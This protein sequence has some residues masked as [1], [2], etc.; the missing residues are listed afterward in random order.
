MG[1]ALRA[2]WV[3]AELGTSCETVAMDFSKGEHRSDWFLAINPMGQ[4][5]AMQE[6]EFNLA[7]SMAIGSYLIERA[8]S[9][10][11]G[12]DAQQR[13]QAWQWSLWSGL[14]LQPHLSTLAAPAWTKQPLAP[15]VEAAAKEGATKYLALLNTHLSKQPFIAGSNFTVAD[16]NVACTVGYAIFSKFDLAPYAAVSAWLSGV[17]DRPAYLQAT[18]SVQK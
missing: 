8:G 14:N 12:K 16:I 2:H 7:E 18:S 10:L 15:S 5:P 3:A 6:G 13:A 1:S 9:D 11:S 4:V 17:T